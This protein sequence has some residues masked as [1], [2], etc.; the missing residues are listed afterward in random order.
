MSCLLGGDNERTAAV[1]Q[2]SVTLTKS[3]RQI[4]CFP[5]G[6]IAMVTAQASHRWLEEGDDNKRE[7]KRVSAINPIDVLTER[8]L[9]QTPRRLV[10][11]IGGG[12]GLNI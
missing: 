5:Y 6:S 10:A 2:P 4:V 8:E 11:L 12:Q 7:N 1:M 3:Y 9:L